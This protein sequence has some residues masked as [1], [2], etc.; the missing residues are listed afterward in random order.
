MIEFEKKENVIKISPDFERSK[1]LLETSRRTL[2]F[3][4]SNK[5]EEYNCGDLI[6]N[7]YESLI[8]ILH[9]HAYKRGFKILDHLSFSEYIENIFEEKTYSKLFD[10]YR[11]MRN[12]IIYYGKRI[13]IE[14]AEQAIKDI[15]EL[16]KFVE[17]N[18]EK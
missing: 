8:E 6:R 17:D 13:S 2:K 1:S 12:G 5:L 11:K 4:S 7:Y 15:K 9:A 16:I 3:S 18:F 10:K 14:I